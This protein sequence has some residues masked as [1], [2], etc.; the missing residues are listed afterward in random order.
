MK[1]VVFTPDEKMYV[2]DFGSPLYESVGKAVGGW[3][4]IVHPRRL[5]SPYCMIVNEEGLLLDLPA[6]P[7]GCFLYQTMV[8][9]SP[10]VGNIVVM[11]EG[12]VDGEP[13]LIGLTEEEIAKIKELA[14]KISDGSIVEVKTE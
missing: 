10:I 1:G 11:K 8:H 7:L 6:N 9:G 14:I 13:D 12:Y 2:Q 4:E 3:I 5:P